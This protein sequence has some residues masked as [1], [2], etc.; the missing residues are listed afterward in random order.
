MNKNG[1]LSIKNSAAQFSKICQVQYLSAAR[2]HIDNKFDDIREHRN[3]ESK[4]KNKGVIKECINIIEDEYMNEELCL[5]YIASIVELS[6]KYLGRIYKNNTGK[7]ISDTIMEYRL[8][9]S[10]QMLRESDKNIKDIIKECGFSN[11]SYFAT[12]F[13]KEFGV[14]PSQ[15][16]TNVRRNK[17]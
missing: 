14:P 13:K 6:P 11:N 5:N 12:A 7:S 16:R 2:E 4:N 15:Y 3:N 8:L 9:K 10:E 1:V 17:Q